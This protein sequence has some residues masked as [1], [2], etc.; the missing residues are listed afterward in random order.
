MVA[1]EF[2]AKLVEA[3]IPHQI[4][5]TRRTQQ[6]LDWLIANGFSWNKKSKHLIGK[7]IDLC[8]YDQFKLHGGNKLN[9]DA[10]DPVWEKMAVIAERLG[11]VCGYRWSNPDCGH[12]EWP[13]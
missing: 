2:I 8:P 1:I 5:N 4:I 10:E 12:Y 3:K 11:L 13:F 6:Q 7:A 9:W